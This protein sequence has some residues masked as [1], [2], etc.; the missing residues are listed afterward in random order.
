MIPLPTG[1]AIAVDGID[2]E[3]PWIFM[4]RIFYERELLSYIYDA[5]SIAESAIVIS[6]DLAVATLCCKVEGGFKEEKCYET[7]DRQ[8]S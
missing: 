4:K 8:Y 6:A 7:R 1:L 5:T 3:S 2:K